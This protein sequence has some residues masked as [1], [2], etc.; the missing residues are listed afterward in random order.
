MSGEVTALRRSLW[1]ISFVY[2]CVTGIRNYGFDLGLRKVSKLDVPVVSV[3]NL[4]VGGTGKTPL[5]VWL[6][7]AARRAGRAPGVLARGYGRAPGA[8]LNDEGE[9]LAR[10]FPDL[11]QVQDP[12]RVRGGRQ[13]VAEHGVDLVILDDGFQ[14]RRLHRDVDILCLDAWRPFAQGLVLPAGDLREAAKP[15]LRRATVAVL[16][17]VDVLE[18]RARIEARIEQVREFARRGVDDLPIFACSHGPSDLTRLD[19]S[20]PEPVAELRAQRVV[21]ASAIARPD[22]FRAT[23]EG[24]GA[25]VVEELT[26]RDHHR[27]DGDDVRRIAARATEL[28]AVV[29]VTEKDAVKLAA[30]DLDARV[31]RIDIEW[32]GG[33]P[34]LA[35]LRIAS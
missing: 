15:G 29:V 4:T 7:E 33:E 28:S 20:D 3:G 6:V 21:L 25:E 19:G 8:R 18:T 5:V 32:F 23:V 2:R 9:L 14:H 16:T 27:F 34:S 13:L 11:P 24:L 10:R 1:P 17:R 12:D 26:F 35:D 22:R 31:L 30:F